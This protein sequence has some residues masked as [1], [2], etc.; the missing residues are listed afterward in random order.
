MTD[1]M[2]DYWF[3]GTNFGVQPTADNYRRLLANGLLKHQAGWH[4]GST[5]QSMLKCHSLVTS[6]GNINRRGKLFIWKYFTNDNV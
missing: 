2:L 4:N 1:E 6:Q 5:M 3:A